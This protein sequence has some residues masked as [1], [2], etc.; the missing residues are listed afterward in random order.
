LLIA[1]RTTTHAGVTVLALLVFLVPPLFA[2]GVWSVW[3][4]RACVLLIIA[5]PCALVISTPVSIVA[6]LTALARRGVLVKGGAHLES[7]GR[8]RALALDKT[9]TLTEGKPQVL[10]VVA[11]GSGE[12]G[13]V[14]RI[15]AAID[16]IPRIR[17]PVR[18]WRTPA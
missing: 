16:D 18:S 5:C 2:G 4:Y 13:E 7:L 12:T 3:L 9:G 10:G 6:G 17:S 1:S 11:L 8:L 15:A 14:V